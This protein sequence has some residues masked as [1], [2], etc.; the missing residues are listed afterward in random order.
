MG[1]GII[2]ENLLDLYSLIQKQDIA[3]DDNAI[4]NYSFVSSFT[5]FSFIYYVTK[6]FPLFQ[7]ILILSSTTCKPP[8]TSGENFA[9]RYNLFVLRFLCLQIQTLFLDWMGLAMSLNAWLVVSQ[10]AASVRD[11]LF[12]SSLR[13]PTI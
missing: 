3:I 8:W 1:W 6:V 5:F 4:R 9:I 13:A 11:K 12:V 10:P 7:Q 2:Q